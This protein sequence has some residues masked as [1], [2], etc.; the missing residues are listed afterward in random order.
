MKFIGFADLD[1]GEQVLGDRV[2]DRI[3]TIARAVI[4]IV[5]FWADDPFVPSQVLEVDVEPLDAALGWAD[6][7]RR[8]ALS[9]D[10][11]VQVPALAYDQVRPPL[12][13]SL[14]SVRWKVAQSF[15]FGCAFTF[16]ENRT[17][18]RVAA[19]ALNAQAQTFVLI[20]DQVT[21]DGYWQGDFNPPR[22]FDSHIQCRQHVFS[23]I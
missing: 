20:Q 17:D 15:P 23:G 4:G 18:V 22:V 1:I 6:P 5:P 3:S 10:S 14:S 19:L 2:L 9:Y 8:V 21:H 11:R 13:V 16:Y 12:I 7:A